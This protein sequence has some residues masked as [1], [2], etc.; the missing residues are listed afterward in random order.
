MTSSP[1][2]AFG[3]CFAL[4]PV[5]PADIRSDP[6]LTARA[7]RRRVADSGPATGAI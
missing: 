7:M 4:R 3:F 5:L 1:A 6:D 2:A